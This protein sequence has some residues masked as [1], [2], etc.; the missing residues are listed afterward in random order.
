MRDFGEFYFRHIKGIPQPPMSWIKTERAASVVCPSACGAES[1][2]SVV[3]RWASPRQFLGFGE[4]GRWG[5]GFARIRVQL[6]NGGVGYGFEAGGLGLDTLCSWG[7]PIGPKI[8]WAAESVGWF[9]VLSL[10]LHGM[11]RKAPW[12]SQTLSYEF[13]LTKAQQ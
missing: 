3:M 11:T 1:E 9:V 6:V 10:L 4:R 7:V 8:G 5:Q 13:D 2:A 12:S